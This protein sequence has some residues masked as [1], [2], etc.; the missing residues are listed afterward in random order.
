VTSTINDNKY[1]EMPIEKW[2][3]NGAQERV[4]KLVDGLLKELNDGE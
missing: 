1:M 4:L 3:S 2:R